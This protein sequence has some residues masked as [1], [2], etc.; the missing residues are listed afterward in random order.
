[1]GGLLVVGNFCTP[2]GKEITMRWYLFFLLGFALF[3]LYLLIRHHMQKIHM[4][5]ERMEEN[6]RRYEETQQQ[7]EKKDEEQTKQLN[8]LSSKV[9][10]NSA[11][12]SAD[13]GR[14]L[15]N[16]AGLSDSY[17]AIRED[18]R[19]IAE[20]VE[21]HSNQLSDIDSRLIQIAVRTTRTEDRISVD[22]R[23]WSKSL[24]IMGETIAKDQANL[25][26]K[27]EE[28]EKNAKESDLEGLWR[29]KFE[30]VGKDIEGLGVEVAEVVKRIEALELIGEQS[31][32]LN[33]Q[34][35]AM[36]DYDPLKALRG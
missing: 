1:M 18:I 29:S 8:E 11:Q 2:P 7:Q 22:R 5:I 26:S 25:R 20:N 15:D 23:D 10:R 34:L 28:L 6:D 33:S 17:K 32:S 19:E 13:Y 27:L 14:C 12:H 30:A 9:T 3:L 31:A 4:L 16:L 35:Q 21:V 24:S 36:A